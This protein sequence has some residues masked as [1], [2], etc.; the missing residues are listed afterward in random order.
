LLAQLGWRVAFTRDW[1]Q[2]IDMVRQAIE[3]VVRAW[4]GSRC[5]TAGQGITRMNIASERRKRLLFPAP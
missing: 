2:G 3:R 4:R 1:D 5:A